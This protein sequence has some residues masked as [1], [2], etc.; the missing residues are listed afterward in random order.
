MSL[1]MNNIECLLPSRV[2]IKSLQHRKMQKTYQQE[3]TL[4]QG[5]YSP[6]RNTKDE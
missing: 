3:R 6:I 1:S 2:F 5:P 4:L